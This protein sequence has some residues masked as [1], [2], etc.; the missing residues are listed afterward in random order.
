MRSNHSSPSRHSIHSLSLYDPEALKWIKLI[1]ASYFESSETKPPVP[2]NQDLP[3]QAFGELTGRCI[4]ACTSHAWFWQSHPD[5]EGV[6]LKLLREFIQRL[7]KRY[8]NTK[9]VIFDDWHSCPQWPRTKKEDEIFHKAMA[10]MNSMYL[11]CDVVLFLEAK[12]PDLDMTV[13]FCTLIPAN[14]SFGTF[15]DVTQFHGPESDNVSIRKNDI[16]VTP[17]DL[18]ILKSTSNEIVISYLKRPFGRPNR[19]PVDKR[20][21]LYAERFT[22]AVKVA[23]AGEHRFEDIVWSNNEELRTA[24]YTWARMLLAAVKRDEI[25]IALEEFKM[26]LKKKQFTRPDDTKVVGELVEELVNQFANDWK[27]EVEKQK[28]MSKRVREILLRWG[29]FSEQYVERAGF[30][31]K[32]NDVFRTLIQMLLLLV[33]PVLTLYM[34]CFDVSDDPLENSNLSGSL[35][36]GATFCIIS[37]ITS[38]ILKVEFLGVTPGLYTIL[39][40]G[41]EFV[42]HFL[43]SCLLRLIFSPFPLEILCTTIIT[44]VVGDQ[45]LYGPKYVSATNPRTNEKVRL[46]L[47]S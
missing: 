19:I 43:L 3:P 45:I 46:T 6:K 24:I 41:K 10:H 42:Q 22:I 47:G 13:R 40:I 38:S 44:V 5:P 17:S 28:S 34:F 31:R 36:V 29:E 26:E 18:D 33:C 7:R 12:L 8:P 25:G 32:E 16:V 27:G 9:I 15:V 11:Y 30:L 14:Y 4:L 2:R 35:F 39:N 37:S 23:T 1:K 21:W 20:G